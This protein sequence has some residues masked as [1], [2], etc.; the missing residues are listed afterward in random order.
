L[1]WKLSFLPKE[2]KQ[3][4]SLDALAQ[5]RILKFLHER[6]LASPDPS[7]DPRTLGKAL[8][9]E[10]EGLWRY[11]VGDYR[12]ICRIEDWAVT[13]LVLEIGHRREIYR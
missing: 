7:F 8:T 3:L 1:E 12:L 9:G 2:Q 13:I 6:L 4:Q 11:R 10:L 5:K